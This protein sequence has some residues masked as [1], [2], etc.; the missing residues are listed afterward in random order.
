MTET[1]TTTADTLASAELMAGLVGHWH[2]SGRVLDSAETTISGTDTYAWLPGRVGLIHFVDVRVGT[3]PVLAVELITPTA[4]QK[5]AFDAVAFAS[6]GTMSR[7]SAE[8]DAED[9]WLFRGGGD[10]APSAA[11]DGAEP[12]SQVRSTLTAEATRMHARWERAADGTAWRP[13]MDMTFI[14]D[15]DIDPADW[16][17]EN[18]WDNGP[19]PT[20]GGPWEQLDDRIGWREWYDATLQR[21]T[22]D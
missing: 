4:E 15:A 10:V 16:P 3:V 22:A 7:M 8:V 2:S 17:P 6:D 13:W 21:R 18:W 14:R 20:S 1:E 12:T 5:R 11:P 9:R 19:G